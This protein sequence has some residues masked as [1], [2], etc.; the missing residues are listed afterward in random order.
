MLIC[1]ANEIRSGFP[2]NQ[3]FFKSFHVSGSN[4]EKFNG[5]SFEDVHQLEKYP[6]SE[7]EKC[8]H[9]RQKK[10]GTTFRHIFEVVP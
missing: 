4:R 8:I 7:R 6:P 3:Q 5:D 1:K 9:V 2:N 10:S